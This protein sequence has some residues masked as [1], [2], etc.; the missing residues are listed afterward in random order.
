MSPS[1]V[2]ILGAGRFAEA[3]ARILAPADLNVRLWARRADARDTFALAHP[4]VECSADIGDVAAPADVVFFAVPAS[5]LDEVANLY[6]DHARG[7]Q[8]VIHA[9]RGTAGEFVLPHRVIRNRSCVRKIGALG[10][11]LHARELQ[12]GRPLAAVIASRF[13]EV[14]A[15]LRRL[16]HNTPVRVHGSRDIV[17]VEV[18]GAI[19]NVSAIAAGM[20]SALDLGDTARGI[21]LT[22]GL[23][24]AQRL[25][26][27]LGAEPMTFAGLAGVGD[28]I[29][30]SVT[31]TDRHDHVGRRLA[32]GESLEDALADAQG[33]VEGVATAVSANRLAERLGLSLPLISAV[34]QIIEGG[35]S[36]SD[37]LERVLRLDDIELGHHL[38]RATR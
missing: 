35:E 8:I 19:S 5:G 26:Y 31:S 2:A 25:G 36:A 7:D 38:V 17:G 24:E 21:L 13:G 4:Q 33:E 15:L 23:V 27:A 18:A 6:G 34:A 37:A 16:A 22:H 3:I 32:F 11:P 12:S 30:R 14:S 20:A 28:L 1:N 29:P 9:V 10:G